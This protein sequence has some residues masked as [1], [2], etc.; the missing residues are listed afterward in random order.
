MIQLQK[1]GTAFVPALPPALADGCNSPLFPSPREVAARYPGWQILELTLWGTQPEDIHS[2]TK[3]GV[4]TLH[5][6]ASTFS[7]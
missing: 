3:S 7:L 4:S 6:P 2:I 5:S 1:T